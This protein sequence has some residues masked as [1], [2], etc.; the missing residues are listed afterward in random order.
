[1]PFHVGTEQACSGYATLFHLQR[2][3]PSGRVAP[4]ALTAALSEPGGVGAK[5]NFRPFGSAPR[6][7]RMARRK[8]CRKR[9]GREYARAECVEHKVKAEKPENLAVHPADP[10][11]LDN[12]GSA[13]P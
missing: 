2:L 8:Q 12:R 9:E 13:H 11:K 10:Q 6:L 1:M 4:L 3:S 7:G 5:G